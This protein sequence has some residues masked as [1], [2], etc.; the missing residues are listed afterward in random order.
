M[1]IKTLLLIFSFL[2][3]TCQASTTNH[4]NIVIIIADDL[5][6]A[7][8][9]YHNQKLFT[10]NIDELA[11]IKLENYYTHPTCTPSR[12]SLLTGKYSFNIGLNVA[13]LPLNPYGIDEQHVTLPQKLKEY[14]YTN[15]YIGKWHL[16]H[17]KKNY[18]ATRKGFDYFY[19]IYNGMAHH[20]EQRMDR[21]YDLR[22][23]FN[24]VKNQNRV[25]S[26]HLYTSRAIDIINNS[27]NNMFMILSYQALHTP[28]TV[29]D[30]YVN[31]EPCKK[32]INHN[33]RIYCG[34]L[35]TIDESIANITRTL[36]DKNMWDNTIILFTT[37][38]GGQVWAGA[39]NDP[40]RGLKHSFYEGSIRGVA[41]LGGGY[42]ELFQKTQTEYHGLMH[43]SDIMPTM[44]GFIGM[45]NNKT[46]TLTGMNFDGMN[47]AE[48]I[49]KSQC[50]VSK[51]IVP[52]YSDNEFTIRDE[53]YKIIV[54]HFGDDHKYENYDN[55]K[56]IGRNIFDQ[57][58]YF[59]TLHISNNNSL[60]RE[61][62][63]EIRMLI[64]ATLRN[65]II[66]NDNS[67]AL[68][69]YNIEWDQGEDNNICLDPK[70]YN[71]CQQIYTDF[72]KRTNFT[73][74]KNYPNNDMDPN[75][76]HNCTNIYGVCFMDSWIPDETD[77]KT[78]KKTKF[79]SYYYGHLFKKSKYKLLFIVL[80][81]I[82]CMVFIIMLLYWIIKKLIF[83]VHAI[84]K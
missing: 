36:K 47:M 28:L 17:A 4:P 25:Y 22:E 12:A 63:Q 69:I 61:V 35:M 71:L 40:L 20:E 66:M 60:L 65:I 64:Y 54:N 57:F 23:N 46:I 29:P 58:I 2:S 82:L 73:F 14:N 72:I 37:D 74:A 77:I 84:L 31:M 8:V 38:N 15:Y 49:K 62:L 9:G 43:I 13:M 68:K 32:I 83:K 5:G 79:R 70:N 44:L 80:I 81:L 52:Y 3:I 45:Q 24:N 7:D 34:M 18:T 78:I 76:R 48:L 51:I 11:T 55:S 42:I 26:T 16:G 1:M 30:K 39:L 19:G 67:S 50:P 27:V 10:P 53:K 6:W 75:Y 56:L 41:F 21:F 59:V 33:R